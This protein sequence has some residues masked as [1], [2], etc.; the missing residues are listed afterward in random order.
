M[1]LSLRDNA[2]H[3][4]KLTEAEQLP[5][6]KPLPESELLSVVESLPE[7]NL[8]AKAK[9]LKQDDKSLRESCP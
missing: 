4:D 7:V 2:L 3:G 9:L 1:E 5:I 6:S 8:L